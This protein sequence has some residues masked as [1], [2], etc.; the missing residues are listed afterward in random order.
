MTLTPPAPA[1]VGIACEQVPGHPDFV[2]LGEIDGIA[3]DLRYA[4]RDNFFGKDLYAFLD[5]AWLHR[6][7][8]FALQKAA[9]TLKA[10]RPDLQLLV[11]DAMR[12][13]RV[14]QMLWDVLQGT[15][16]RQYVG[17]PERGSIHSFGMA[18]DITLADLEGQE[19]DM[20]S[21]FDEMSERSHPDLEVQLLALGQITRQHVAN[22]ELL[23]RVMVDAGFKGI[24]NE[25]WHF[26][27]GDSRGIRAVYER[28]L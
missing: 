15:Q 12:P 28:I 10:L 27:C 13:Q 4:G 24:P 14:Q 3:V 1:L 8:A 9:H 18:V 23:R 7:A 19:L 11:L 17:A 25:W 21:H 2:G 5:C 16:L 6:D 20:G 22:R 26:D